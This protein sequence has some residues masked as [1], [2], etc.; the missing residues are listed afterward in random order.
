MEALFLNLGTFIIVIGVLVFFH[1]AGHFSVAK[2]FR[3]SVETFSLGFG[4]RL[5]GFKRGETDYR[6]SAIPLGGYVK[7]LGEN[8]DELEE[9]RGLQGALVSKPAW[10]RFFI[11][12][13][14][15]LA[16]LLLAIVIP[17]ALYMFSYEVP[18]YRTEP[19]RV[20]FVAVGS[21]AERA[22]I[23]PGDLVVQFDGLNNPTWAELE[24]YTALKPGERVSVVIERDGQRRTLTLDIM[25]TTESG[26]TIGFTGLLPDL[27]GDGVV[28]N[29]VQPGTPAERAGLRPGDKIIA[30][31]GL[32]IKNM[33]EVTACVHPNVGRALTFTILREG[34]RLDVH[35]TPFFD[36]A[37]GFGR[38]GFS[39]TPTLPPMVASRLGPIEAFAEAV[40][41]N[42]HYLGLIAEALSS[43]AKGRRSIRET[44]A[45]PVGIAVISGEAAQ[46]GLQ[47]FLHMMAILSLSLGIFNLFPVP[48][49]DGGQIFMLFLEK[50]FHWF[51]Q[52]MSVSLREK[53]Q[54]IGFA[55]LVFLMGYMIY[56]DIAKLIQ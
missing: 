23:R 25:E 52:E 10:Q 51:G 19:A 15:P 50:G 37:L 55:V 34:R 33:K 56:A 31:N 22:G 11:F 41:F 14:G 46:Q 20:G 26:E 29:E 39:A 42:A 36:E 44:F 5:F 16:N 28:I 38:V 53:I 7:M 2:L 40:R 32:P 43:I 4:P 54:T 17:A 21:P 48:V 24:D 3:V 35:L 18:A 12:L 13:A 1:E 27:P 6:V 30:I 45:G 9:T 8:P 49:L 47:S